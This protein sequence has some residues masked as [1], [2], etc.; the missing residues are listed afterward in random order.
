MYK[1]GLASNNLQQLTCHKIQPNQKFT[2]FSNVELCQETKETE[3]KLINIYVKAHVKTFSL[4][5]CLGIH[6]ILD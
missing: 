4:S 3:N 2:L 5:L 1:K 6:V